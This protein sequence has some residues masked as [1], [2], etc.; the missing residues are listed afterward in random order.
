VVRALII[1]I[2]DWRTRWVNEFML[3]KAGLR[4]AQ[5]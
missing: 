2:K 1:G 5:T 3:Q 4:E